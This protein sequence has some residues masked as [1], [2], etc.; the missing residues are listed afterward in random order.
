[1]SV[2]HVLLCH[3]IQVFFEGI[4]LSASPSP[5]LFPGHMTNWSTPVLANDRHRWD[6]SFKVF[7]INI[8][9]KKKKKKKKNALPKVCNSQPTYTFLL[10]AI[11]SSSFYLVLVI[12]FAYVERFSVT[13]MRDFPLTVHL[14]PN[15]SSLYC[16]ARGTVV[17]YFI[18]VYLQFRVECELNIEKSSNMLVLRIDG[19]YFTFTMLYILL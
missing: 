15:I 8:I 4:L 3:Y 7:K 5:F 6:P 11:C 18:F 2:S 19:P 13:R 1:M 10:N 17:W 16:F 9:Y 14:G 12:V